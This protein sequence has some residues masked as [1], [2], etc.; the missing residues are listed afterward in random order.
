MCTVV[1]FPLNPCGVL[2]SVVSHMPSTPACLRAFLLPVFLPPCLPALLS[3]CL[4]A[5][6]PPCL[7]ASLP[8]WLPAHTVCPGVRVEKHSHLWLSHCTIP[9]RWASA[10]YDAPT[11]ADLAKYIDVQVCSTGSTVG[12]GVWITHQNRHG[13]PQG[14]SCSRALFQSGRRAKRTGRPLVH[15]VE[16]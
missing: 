8:A 6:L 12:V 9:H 1:A 4:P 15:A 14:E 3:P 10:S 5:S 7:P 13:G 11:K 2:A 16:G